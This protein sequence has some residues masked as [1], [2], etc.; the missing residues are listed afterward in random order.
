M[1]AVDS[2]VGNLELNIPFTISALTEEAD[3]VPTMVNYVDINAITAA[4]GLCGFIHP[5]NGCLQIAE[6]STTASTA[7]E[8]ADN[9]KATSFLGFNFSYIVE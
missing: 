9:I 4:G 8:A 5:T 1:S 7:T 2:P 6:A 3:V